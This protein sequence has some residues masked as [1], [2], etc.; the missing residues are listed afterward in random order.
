GIR[1][2]VEILVVKMLDKLGARNDPSLVVRKIGQKAIFKR[3]QLHRIAIERD[4]AP[5]VLP[6]RTASPDSRRPRHRSRQPCR[7]TDRAPSESAPAWCGRPFA[8]ARAPG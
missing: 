1:I 2:A 5:A 3:G 8:S 7:S 6:Y 4:P